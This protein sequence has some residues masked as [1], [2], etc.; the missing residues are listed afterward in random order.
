MIVPLPVG[1]ADPSDRLRLV[2]EQTTRHRQGAS[3]RRLPVL[4]SRTLQRAAMHLAAR[5]RAYNVYVA[6][7][8]GPQVPLYLAGARLVEVFPVVPLMGNLTVGVGALSYCD[9][10]TILA[11][12]DAEM[13]PDLEVFAAGVERTMSWLTSVASERQERANAAPGTARADDTVPSAAAQL[14]P[15]R[16]PASAG[17]PVPRPPA[18]DT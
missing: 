17:Q 7:V 1:V 2:A 10:F 3:P 15:R 4:R 14:R 6:N 11:V 16:G 5:Q 8:P 18:A 12:G 9:Q 13:C